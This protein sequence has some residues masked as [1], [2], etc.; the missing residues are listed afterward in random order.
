MIYLLKMKISN[1]MEV[2]LRGF[3]VT[4]NNSI[5]SYMNWTAQRGRSVS[6]D[7][8]VGVGLQ[9]NTGNLGDKVKG[10]LKKYLSFFSV[11]VGGSAKMGQSQSANE[12]NSAR[13]AWDARGG[14][15][16]FLSVGKAE[17]EIGV[18][19]FQKCL[20]IKPRPNSFIAS[21]QSGKPKEYKNL[22]S[23]N[24]TDFDKIVFS[25]P[26][27]IL[28]NPVEK[29]SPDNLQKITESYYY[30]SQA[31]MDPSNSQFLDLYDLA[32]RPF[33][34]I[35]RGKREFLKFYHLTRHISPGDPL[36]AKPE[37]MFIEYR[38][39]VEQAR[40]ISL[41]LT[42]VTS[43][44]FYPGIYD[45]PYD[46]NEEIDGSHLSNDDPW[47]AVDLHPFDIFEVPNPKET[48]IPIQN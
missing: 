22:W 1:I 9:S 30:I 45:Y 21:F 20:V 28:C 33:I 8:S 12:S 6:I 19:E 2:F 15:A 29:R 42:E 36:N 43:T 37:N 48:T 47:N 27:L 46:V 5:G 4:K 16:V 39:I 32:N 31:N 25:R 34:T 3:S 44:G 38:D 24:V 41:K 35:L 13:I 23:E 10:L 14:D 7:A 26:G 40:G 11:S 18:K 17:V